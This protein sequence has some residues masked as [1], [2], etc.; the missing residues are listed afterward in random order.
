[1]KLSSFKF[2]GFYDEDQ[3]R[4]YETDKNLNGNNISKIYYYKDYSEYLF[5]K[6]DRKRVPN[7]RELDNIHMFVMQKEMNKKDS[8]ARVCFGSTIAAVLL[9]SLLKVGYDIVK[10]N[11]DESL[12]MQEKEHVVH[13]IGKAYHNIDK[14]D[15]KNKLID[16]IN[17]AEVDLTDGNYRILYYLYYLAFVGEMGEDA[18]L[19]IANVLTLN[20]RMNYRDFFT[21]Y[22]SDKFN[23]E[24]VMKDPRGDALKATYDNIDIFLELNMLL[25]QEVVEENISMEEYSSFIN[26]FGE[27]LK[28]RDADLYRIWSYKVSHSS[29]FGELVN[30]KYLI[31]KKMLEKFD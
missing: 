5:L 26:S 2:I 9:I 6:D 21:F 1:M 12:T 11:L 18:F 28:S 8:L 25:R 27:T 10:N 15:I 14:E 22:I 19:D 3:A 29:M 30:F 23:Y 31:Y 24:S 7:L 20:G 13:D 4:I 16:M 17:M